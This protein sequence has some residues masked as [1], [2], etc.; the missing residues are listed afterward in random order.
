MRFLVPL[1]Q[2][3][4]NQRAMADLPLILLYDFIGL[5]L[6][7]PGASGVRYANQA[8]GYSCLQPEV[9]GYLVPLHNDLGLDPVELLGPEPE[10]LTYF[11]G[12][13]HRG[14]GATSGLDD[15]DAD[16]LDRILV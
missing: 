11:G 3:P 12:P 13:K 9:E 2:G 4:P 6:I 7:L 14:A 5:G 1:A 15:Q 8:G 16:E 10:L